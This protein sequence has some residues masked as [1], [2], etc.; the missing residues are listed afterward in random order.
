MSKIG[1]LQKS[2]D[3]KTPANL[4]GS[5]RTLKLDVPVMLEPVKEPVTNGPAYEVFALVGGGEIIRIGAAWRKKS[6]D[7]KR[8]YLSLS[9]DDPSWNQPLSCA[10]FPSKVAGEY[11]VVWNRPR[12]REAA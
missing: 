7:G 4:Y 1:N 12:E 10:A 8:E 3:V 6:E 11:D 5:I 2:K 9:L